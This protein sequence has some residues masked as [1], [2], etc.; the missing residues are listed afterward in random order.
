MK[1]QAIALCAILFLETLFNTSTGL[2][3]K[4]PD[5]RDRQ[6]GLGGF[7]Y[8]DYPGVYPAYYPGHRPYHGR[9]PN[10]SFNPYRQYG[11]WCGRTFCPWGYRCETMTVYCIRAPCP[12]PKRCVPYWYHRSQRR[13]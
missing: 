4:H 9:W 3:N 2:P 6:L 11:R 1:F 10:L 13:T 5:S 12:Q 8:G 7:N